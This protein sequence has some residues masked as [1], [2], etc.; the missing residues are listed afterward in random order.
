MAWSGIAA[1]LLLQ[2]QTVHSVF[3]LPMHCEYQDV[4]CNIKPDSKYA[5]LLRN[6]AVFIIDE[7]S[8]VPKYA[9]QAIDKL[10]Q[11][12]HESTEPFGGAVMLLGG[13]FRQ[14][15]PVLRGGSASE[16][17]GITIRACNLWECFQ[18][19][20]LTE[21]MRVKK[22]NTEE[23]KKRAE[24]HHQYLLQVGNG[25]ANKE[26]YLPIPAD[27]QCRQKSIADYVYPDGFDFSD[28][29]AL[30][31]RA[32]L[33]PKNVTSL[34]MNEQILKRLPGETK[35]YTSIDTVDEGENDANISL[36]YP[37]EWLYKQTPSGLPPHELN[38]K[39]GAIVMLLR[40]LHVRAGLCNGTR[41]IVRKMME[42]SLRCELIAG[43]QAGESVFIPRID[44]LSDPESDLPIALRRRQFPIRLAFSMTI[45]KSQGQSLSRV[46]ILLKSQCFSHGQ[47]YVA[48]S[49]CTTRENLAIMSFDEEEKRLNEAVNVVIKEVLLDPH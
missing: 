33:C 24:D 30:S 26:H 40:N 6:T 34:E 13:D 45:N 31:E 41:M 28:T 8:M 37:T 1:T 20:T 47:M 36:L 43:P 49:R 21:N 38:L 27:L 17:V 15:L 32:I 39:E 12:I 29:K 14:I 44:L 11:E 10:L 22:G 2:G 42:H 9:L 25:N 7:A 46:G 5:E 19:F 18:K 4:A 3:K 48:M 16:Q 35:T 23:E